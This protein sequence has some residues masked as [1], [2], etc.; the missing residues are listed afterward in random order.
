V[1]DVVRASDVGGESGTLLLRHTALD[2]VVSD[3]PDRQVTET[4]GSLHLTF[5]AADFFQ[6]NP[7]LL[8]SLVEYVLVEAQGNLETDAASCAAAPCCYLID[9]YCGSGLFA[10][11]AAARFEKCIGVETSASAVEA[12]RRNAAANGIANAEFVAGSAESIFASVRFQGAQTAMIVDPPRKGCSAAFLMQLLRFA[13]RRIVYVS[14]GPDTQAR[15]L[16]ILIDA[17]YTITRVTPFDLFPHTRHIESVATLEWTSD[18]A[19]KP[20]VRQ[21][22]EK[23]QASRT[24]RRRNRTTRGRRSRSTQA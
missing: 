16:R 21:Q 5:R 19:P 17:G 4:V 15:D 9:A 14:C 3:N 13:P 18:D 10:L 2:G 12:A 7:H 23:R 22:V 8:P 1:R 11:S 24:G 20:I 6:N